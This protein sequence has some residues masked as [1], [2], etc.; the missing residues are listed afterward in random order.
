M[1][2]YDTGTSGS[3]GRVPDPP[4]V[5]ETWG[6]VDDWL[7][8]RVD[9]VLE[10]VWDYVSTVAEVARWVLERVAIVYP[11]V[12]ERWATGADERV[13]PECGP[14]HGMVWPEGEGAVPPL[15]VN[16]RCRREQAYVEWR[17]RYVDEWRLRWT[18]SVEWEWRITGWR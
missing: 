6:R 11:V 4:A 2:G 5:R 18:T 15:H 14:L 9:D 7:R 12:H 16:C 13:C 3:G 1:I 8:D 17:T 10:P